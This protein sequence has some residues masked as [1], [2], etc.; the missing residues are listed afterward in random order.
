MA[1][2]LDSAPAQFVNFAAI[3]FRFWRSHGEHWE[4][5]RMVLM[6]IQANEDLECRNGALERDRAGGGASSAEGDGHPE[7]SWM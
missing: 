5:A 6:L 2:R 1:A 3:S 4:L 7:A